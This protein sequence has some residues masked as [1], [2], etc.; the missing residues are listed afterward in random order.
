MRYLADEKVDVQPKPPQHCRDAAV[1]GASFD[2]GVFQPTQHRP[3]PH[4]FPRG[5]NYEAE[6]DMHLGR[7]GYD[8][9]YNEGYFMCTK[10]AYIAAMT[11]IQVEMVCHLEV[12]FNL[13]LEASMSDLVLLRHLKHFR[14]TLR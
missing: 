4:I 2:L 5:G 1:G 11:F 8:R 9:Y 10:K 14:G 13:C 6:V 12:L 7:Q 3:E